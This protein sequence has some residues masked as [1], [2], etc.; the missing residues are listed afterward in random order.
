[1]KTENTSMSYIP[2]KSSSEVE[3]IGFQK[4]IQDDVFNR[5]KHIFKFEYDASKLVTIIF[6]DDCTEEDI[7]SY[8]GRYE[9]HFYDLIRHNT[10]VRE[11]V[12]ID[13]PRK[14][15]PSEFV[16]E[17][18]QVDED[19]V[20]HDIVQKFIRSHNDI[21]QGECALNNRRLIV[22]TAHSEKK[23]SVHIVVR[24]VYFACNSKQQDFMRHIHAS[25]KDEYFNI[26]TS[27]YSK[28]RCFR[29]LNNTKYKQDR[30]LRV[31]CGEMYNYSSTL[32][33]SIVFPLASLSDEEIK[34]NMLEWNVSPRANVH[35]SNAT[36]SKS[37]SSIAEFLKQ[38]PYFELNGMR[39]NRIDDTT[40]PCLC[41]P[42]D[43]HSSENMYLF[44]THDALYARCFCNKG[45]SILIQRIRKKLDLPIEKSKYTTHTFKGYASSEEFKHIIENHDRVYDK[46]QTGK[47]K[48]A[49]FMNWAI[50][51]KKKF[52][53]ISNRQ[54]LDE[55]YIREYPNVIVSYR[56][57]LIKKNPKE[58]FEGYKDK[59]RGV[60]VVINSLYK[61]LQ[62]L[63]MSLENFDAI[64]IDEV[65]SN[66]RQFEMKGKDSLECDMSEFL[67]IVG[68]Y[69]G[70]VLML[71]ANM[72]D[73][74]I[75]K[76]TSIRK[77]EVELMVGKEYTP[78]IAVIETE[79]DGTEDKP[80]VIVYKTKH[81]N[82]FIKKVMSAYANGEK[83][84]VP[85]NVGPDTITS[86]MR[87]IQSKYPN[88]SYLNINAQTR[89]SYDLSDESLITYDCLCYS[90]TISEGVS[91]S[92]DIFKDHVGYG[93]FTNQSSPV[94]GV[95]QM[96]KRFRKVRTY[97]VCIRQHT[98]QSSPYHTEQEYYDYAQQHLYKLACI[99]KKRVRDPTSGMYKFQI[100]KDDMWDLHLLNVMED[101][102]FSQKGSF[103]TKFYQLCVNNGFDVYT[104]FLDEELTK[105][106][107]DGLDE[108]GRI[109]QQIKEE[110]IEALT[111]ARLISKAEYDRLDGVN[112]IE[113]E[114]L[115]SKYII[116]EVATPHLNQ[117]VSSY[118][119]DFYRYWS[120]PIHRKKMYRLR[121]LIQFH[122]DEKG[123][124]VQ[125]SEDVSLREYT[126]RVLERYNEFNFYNQRGAINTDLYRMEQLA[127]L[128]RKLG[129]T[130]LPD[131]FGSI[132]FKVFTKN[133]KTINQV[134]IST[135]KK[136]FRVQLDSDDIIMFSEKEWSK[137]SKK[138][139][140]L[141]FLLN[142]VYYFAGLKLTCDGKKVFHQ[143]ALECTLT[144]SDGQAYVMNTTFSDEIID[145]SERFFKV[146]YCYDCQ[147][148]VPSKLIG[149][150]YRT[151][152]HL[153]NAGEFTEDDLKCV[154]CGLVFKKNA[155]SAW[156]EHKNGT[157]EIPPC[158]GVRLSFEDLTCPLCS[159]VFLNLTDFDKHR[160]KCHKCE[161]CDKIFGHRGHYTKH[162]EV[163][164]IPKPKKEYKCDKCQVVC[165]D[166][167]DYT[168]HLK[169]NGHIER[170]MSTCE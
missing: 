61:T 57:E 17:K 166:K 96:I 107:D 8:M 165:K 72:T 161:K 33:A 157:D 137:A 111:H 22:M 34:R 38:H 67:N 68:S 158:D 6:K 154:K 77:R 52:L 106:E 91:F 30:P 41:D 82:F 138:T 89:Q 156:E 129:F 132:P 20:V 13:L 128:N 118:D 69:N 64:C 65:Q 5:R 146:N 153:I 44:E 131:L 148:E 2:L 83:I 62:R 149:E 117:S 119:K 93:F 49:S 92:S 59:A 4:N 152:T 21:A 95:N 60:S 140:G 169:T 81:E 87:T 9:S 105:E 26:D 116:H 130:I 163:C 39:L 51:H 79:D 139:K 36:I 134:D 170:E 24:D 12:D 147:C 127:K 123:D 50:E 88:F 75:E 18:E 86:Y 136:L 70:K 43:S 35:V 15:I 19:A 3:F 121:S 99:S 46:R 29:L 80:R 54:S 97:H 1:M 168:R 144:P 32:Q 76:L 37:T 78:K 63:S 16:D 45:Q 135:I 103:I 25:L 155:F 164:G 11:Y 114:L 48:T 115:K 94:F 14:D 151:R 143:T 55:D 28:N 53:I 108:Y 104:D 7:K 58:V 102:Q 101:V 145:G 42:S 31:F 85:Y 40:R 73:E 160:S 133:L 113:S 71:D 167:T 56:N 162:I 23:L 47:G 74:L 84:I 159:S 90:P 125:T 150:H 112:T 141:L 10:P 124:V 66:V 122:H 100:V 98:L 110:H 126:Q 27:V 109:K 142:Q 120:T